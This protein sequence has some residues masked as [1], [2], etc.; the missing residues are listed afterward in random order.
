[1]ALRAAEHGLCL[2][3]FED[4]VLGQFGFSIG[5]GR[6]GL[7]G[8]HESWSLA[9]GLPEHHGAGLPQSPRTATAS[10]SVFVRRKVYSV[11]GDFPVG[12]PTIESDP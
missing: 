11:V 6:W 2:R 10:L 4:F 12:F 7:H 1:M 9:W 8:G 3:A 5:G